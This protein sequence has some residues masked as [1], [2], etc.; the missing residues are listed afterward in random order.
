M[1][2]ELDPVAASNSELKS[3]PSEDDDEVL[4]PNNEARSAED[5]PTELIAIPPGQSVITV[6][7]G[8]G[9]T[10]PSPQK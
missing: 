5:K 3:I 2:S 8:G 6:R 9:I 7:S 10:F 1:P 4:D